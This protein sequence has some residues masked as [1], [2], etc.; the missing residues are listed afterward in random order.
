[1]RDM[2]YQPLV[3]ILIPL[4]NQERYFEKCIR[5]VCNQTYKNLEIIVVNDGSTDKSSEILSK[6]A[7]RDDRIKVVNKQNEGLPMARKDGYL[8]ATGEYICF[9]DSDDQLVSNGVEVMVKHIMRHQVDMVICTAKRMLGILKWSRITGPFPKDHVVRQPELFNQYYVNFFGKASFPNNMWARLIKKTAIDKAY[10]QT[11]IFMTELRFMGEDLYFNMKIFPHLQSMVMTDD[12]V[13]YYRYG[14][15]VDHFNKY[16][17]ELFRLADIRL[18][19]LDQYSYHD[20]YEPLF[21]EYSN[22]I[23]YYAEQLLEFKKSGYQVIIDFFR[24]ELSSREIF[25]RMQEFFA[26]HECHYT[27]VGLM[28]N[29]DYDGMYNYAKDFLKNRCESLKYR[30]QRALL[31]IIEHI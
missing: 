5:S 21:V 31:W 22:M 9:V 23:Y 24:Q 27:G 26:S 14:G 2:D 25:H 8:N 15:T 20:G 11:D 19:Q 16:Y 13:Y 1:M 10:Q 7:S 12:I 3:S 4:Y 28:L 29:N 6:W 18:S 30:T 17:P